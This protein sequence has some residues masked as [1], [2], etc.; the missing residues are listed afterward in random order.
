MRDGALSQAQVAPA[1]PPP[2]KERVVP[3]PGTEYPLQDANGRDIAIKWWNVLEKSRF[4]ELLG[5]Q[6]SA[7]PQYLNIAVPAFLASTIGEARLG[8]PA[9]RT[10]LDGRIQMLGDAGIEAISLFLVETFGE[11]DQQEAVAK[12]KNAPGTLG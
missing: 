3:I 12:L 7:N 8:R 4:F 5:A 9:S 10:Q 1:D 2:S 11:E 6:N